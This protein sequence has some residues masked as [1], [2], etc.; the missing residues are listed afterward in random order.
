MPRKIGF[1]QTKKGAY[2]SALLHF[3]MKTGLQ[4]FER[5]RDEPRITCT[6]HQQQQ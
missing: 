4:F 1:I 2:K 5:Q 6:A 3:Q